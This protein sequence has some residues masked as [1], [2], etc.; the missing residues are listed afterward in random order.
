M[1]NLSQQQNL[2]ESITLIRKKFK[3]GRTEFANLL[4]I[5]ATGERTVRGWEQGEHVPSSRK[6]E[7]IRKLEKRL[8]EVRNNAPF[9]QPR[10]R[11]KFIDLFAGI[12]GIR[13]PF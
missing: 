12:G 7:D 5:G 1:K 13:L 2:A 6:L 8:L 3:I 9:S 4:G 11:F 10:S